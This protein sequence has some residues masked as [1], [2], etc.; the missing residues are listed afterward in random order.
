MEFEEQLKIDFE[1]IAKNERVDDLNMGGTQ[2]KGCLVE[3]TLDA[4]SEAISF[5]EDC[6]RCVQRSAEDLLGSRYEAESQILTS[7]AGHDSVKSSHLMK[8]AT[9]KCWTRSSQA[10]GRRLR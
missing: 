7:G 9:A 2:G 3:W 4:P 8:M 1:G 10:K 5:D 6:I